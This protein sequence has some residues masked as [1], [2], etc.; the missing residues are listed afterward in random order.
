MTTGVDAARRDEFLLR[1]YDQTREHFRHLE[2]LRARHLGFLF[3]VWFAAVAYVA[4][5]HAA[6]T[7]AW[8]GVGV[9][10]IGLLV[11]LLACFTYISVRKFGVALTHNRKVVHKIR[12]QFVGDDDG[13][14]PAP[15]TSTWFTRTRLFTVQG[16][17]E[18]TCLLAAATS[19]A[20][21]SGL[22]AHF[23]LRGGE[24]GPETLLVALACAGFGLLAGVLAVGDRPYWVAL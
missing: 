4:S 15:E 6:L 23:L 9:A 8:E 13:A 14:P 24:A 16:T 22:A 20:A 18:L 5:F 7:S 11:T 19:V 10:S 1:E 17:S 2:G 21:E 12:L 3:T